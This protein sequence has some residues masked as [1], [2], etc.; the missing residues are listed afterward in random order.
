MYFERIGFQAQPETAVDSMNLGIRNEAYTELPRVELKSKEEAKDSS[1]Q[2]HNTPHTRSYYPKMTAQGDG[3][4]TIK[5][6]WA[7]VALTTVAVVLRLYT[8]IFVVHSYAMDDNVYNIA[9]VSK[10]S[11]CYYLRVPHH[12]L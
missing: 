9:F 1:T 8:R 10:T 2:L 4:E 7:L 5:V 11:F 6:M 12:Y 3:L